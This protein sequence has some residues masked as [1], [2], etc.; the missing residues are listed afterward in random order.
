MGKVYNEGQGRLPDFQKFILDKK[1]V[2]NKNASF[3]AY[4]VSR[5]LDYALQT[6]KK[7]E[8]SDIEA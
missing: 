3:Y 8:I 5:F 6:V 4:W 2:P 1:L 7:G